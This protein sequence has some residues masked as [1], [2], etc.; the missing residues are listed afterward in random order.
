VHGQ[1]K[2]EINMYKKIFL[3]F[4]FLLFAACVAEIEE[5]IISEETIEEESSNYEL[6]EPEIL[7]EEPPPEEA[8]STAQILEI[9]SIDAFDIDVHFELFDSQ[10]SVNI[11][12]II[13]GNRAQTLIST[14]LEPSGI[15]GGFIIPLKIYTLRENGE[16]TDTRIFLSGEELSKESAVNMGIA[17]LLLLADFDIQE[18]ISKISADFFENFDIHSR[19]IYEETRFN[20]FL[21]SD[22]LIVE[23]PD[24]LGIGTISPDILNVTVFTEGNHLNGYFYLAWTPPEAE[25]PIS[26][27]A[28]FYINAVGDAVKISLPQ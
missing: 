22:D 6:I 15:L 12:N 25:E 9:L 2:K 20:L 28:H 14:E 4:I 24:F 11:K 1:K 27:T 21:N 19:N 3:I 26:A 18:I 13:D 17:D 5:E 23:M 8:E 16:P 7:E 10:M